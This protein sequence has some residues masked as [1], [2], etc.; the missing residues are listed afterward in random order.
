MEF[1]DETTVVMTVTVGEKKIEPVDLPA[2]IFTRDS[3]VIN[4]LQLDPTCEVTIKK[5]T[6]T[7][8]YKYKTV[9]LKTKSVS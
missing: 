3:G 5:E 8:S 1:I 9:V 7:Y 2:R 4:L 6:G